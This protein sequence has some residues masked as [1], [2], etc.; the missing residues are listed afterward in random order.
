MLSTTIKLGTRKAEPQ[1]AAASRTGHPEVARTQR[2][3][4]RGHCEPFSKAR[5]PGLRSH[6][7]AL[8]NGQA[9]PPS[10]ATEPPST[11]QVHARARTQGNPSGVHATTGTRTRTA[12]WFRTTRAQAPNVTD[13]RTWEQNAAAPS[14]RA[15]PRRKDAV[16]AATQRRDTVHAATWRDDERVTLREGGQTQGTTCGANRVCGTSQPGQCTETESRWVA[17][18]GEGRGGQ[19]AA[20]VHTGRLGRH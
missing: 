8:A 17:S 1:G 10:A 2:R 5:P 11:R 15:G 7:A 9:A 3:P 13:W 6:A 16:H 20:T 19:G 12:A 4:S 14:S 18:T